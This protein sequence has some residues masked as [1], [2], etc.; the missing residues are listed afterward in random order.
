MI[1]GITKNSATKLEIPAAVLRSKAPNATDQADEQQ[2]DPRADHH[3]QR[4]GIGDPRTRSLAGEQRLP[5]EER[6]DG[7][8]DGRDAH[9]DG[10][11]G[12][13]RPEH[14]QALRNRGQ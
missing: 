14:G 10:E 2:V 9:N 13:L 11:H 8:G 6:D 7:R 5:Q 1:G 3:P 12:D 4:A